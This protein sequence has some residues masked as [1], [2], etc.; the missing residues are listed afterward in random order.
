MVCRIAASIRGCWSNLPAMRPAARPSTSSTVTFLLR[1]FFSGD[2]SA[3]RSFWR[4][5]FTACAMEASSFACASAA[6]RALLVALWVT[7]SK[8]FD[9]W[10]SVL[11]RSAA[12]SPCGSIARR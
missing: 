7:S 10:P 3:S 8:R 4:K 9:A 11:H 1:A 12:V 6:F 5:S 2:A